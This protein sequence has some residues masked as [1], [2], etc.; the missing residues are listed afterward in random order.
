[1]F[2]ISNGGKNV[3][4]TGMF[5]AWHNLQTISQNTIH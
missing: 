4:V 5:S 3:T 2:L 1:M